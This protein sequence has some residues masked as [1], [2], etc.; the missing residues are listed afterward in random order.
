MRELLHLGLDIGQISN[1]F[2]GFQTGPHKR[3]KEL[4]LK[5]LKQIKKVFC[6]K[7]VKTLNFCKK[8]NFSF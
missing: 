5:D 1:T 7:K 6:K 2:L 3:N 4:Q 8:F